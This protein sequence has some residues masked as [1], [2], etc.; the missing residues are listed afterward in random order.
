MSKPELMTQTEEDAFSRDGYL[1]IPGVLAEEEVEAMKREA[2]AAVDEALATKTEL[3]EAVYHG[4]SFKVDNILRRSTAFDVLIDHP[5]VLG[6]LISA[7]GKH[8]QLMGSEIFVRGPADDA[9]T[10]FHTDLGEA[11]QQ[12]LPAPGNPMLQVKAQFFLTDLSIPDASNFVL[13]PGSHRM[14]VPTPNVDCMID[15]I[16]E[17]GRMPAEARQIL[18]RPGDVLLFAW[19]LW[20]AV[21]PNRSGRTRLSITLRYGQLA[22][23]PIEEFG[24]LLQDGDRFSERQRRLLGDVGSYPSSYWKPARQHELLFG[25]GR[26]GEIRRE[27]R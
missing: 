17:G 24:D 16:N 13:I 21:A 11:M 15:H 25:D 18:A 10:G 20:H 23:R 5:K 8:V 22:L 4:G 14:R 19:T 12:A 26:P 6:R 2:Q 3:R 1:L 27:G 9:I 7:I